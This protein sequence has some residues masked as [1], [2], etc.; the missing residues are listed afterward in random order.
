MS[1]IT[2]RNSSYLIIHILITLIHLYFYLY[3]HILKFKCKNPKISMG[4]NS[5]RPFRS[6]NWILMFIQSRLYHY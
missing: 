5:V 3:S 6:Q 1:A 4:F 2:Y